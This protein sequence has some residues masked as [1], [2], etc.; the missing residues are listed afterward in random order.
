MLGT[1]WV[2]PTAT[3]EAKEIS[4]LVTHVAGES[5]FVVPA[6]A[7]TQ[8]VGHGDIRFGQ[9]VI[10]VLMG[11]WV[12]L[13]ELWELETVG[14][15]APA[16]LKECRRSIGLAVRGKLPV[17]AAQEKLEDTDEYLSWSYRVQEATRNILQEYPEV[18]DWDPS[19]YD[20]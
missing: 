5:V 11:E 12:Y 13:D 14:G 17:T 20:L 2:D 18:D 15:V 7:R 3:G 10:R 9:L 16:V 4:F 19:F 1:K 8:L 6:D